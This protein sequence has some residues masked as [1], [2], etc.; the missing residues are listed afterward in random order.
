M[1]SRLH[2]L[3]TPIAK[4]PQPAP[5]KRDT[6]AQPWKAIMSQVKNKQEDISAEGARPEYIV[7]S[8]GDRRLGGGGHLVA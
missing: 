5:A 8:N 1:L 7:I 3:R 4:M 2:N 6:R